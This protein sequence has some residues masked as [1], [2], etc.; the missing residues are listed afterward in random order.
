VISP[1][2]ADRYSAAFFLGPNPDAIVRVSADLQRSRP[3]G[4]ICA[5]YGG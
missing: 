4:E 5:D 3:T 1:P 2:G